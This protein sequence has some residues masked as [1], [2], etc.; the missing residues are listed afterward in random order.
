MAWRYPWYD[1]VESEVDPFIERLKDKGF[2]Y[3]EEDKVWERVWVVAT[4]NGSE[5]SKEV[6][7]KEGNDWRV[8]MYG[9]NGEV[10]FEHPVKENE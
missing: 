7:K 2:H 4:K 1:V 3:S 10:F 6:Y 9:D 5:R 8:I